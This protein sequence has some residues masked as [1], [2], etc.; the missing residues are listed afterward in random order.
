[1]GS[2]NRLTDGLLLAALI[3]AV[4]FIAYRA[5]LF[6]FQKSQNYYADAALL[7][8]GNSRVEQGVMRG[9]VDK[10]VPGGAA[11]LASQGM[12]LKIAR[13]LVEAHLAG[14]GSTRAIWLSV[15][16]WQL[17]DEYGEQGFR[18]W[19]PFLGKA[20]MDAYLRTVMAERDYLFMKWIPLLRFNGVKARLLRTAI[21]LGGVSVNRNVVTPTQIREVVAG[22]AQP[23]RVADDKLRDLSAICDLAQFRGV[24]LR[25]FFM[26]VIPELAQPWDI[27]GFRGKVLGLLR[28]YPS[29]RFVDFNDRLREH[30]Y[31]RDTGH[32]NM[33]GAEAFSAMFVDSLTLPDRAP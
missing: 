13:S 30:A 29:V 16:P 20:P 11:F 21:G 4:H 8:I 27:P 28:A 10:R 32:L 25:L 22:Y 1:M 17:S 2:R 5:A 6:L 19:L 23:L 18:N 31:F 9:K 15:D 14:T 3:V 26:P 12:D 7:V 33:P 24:E